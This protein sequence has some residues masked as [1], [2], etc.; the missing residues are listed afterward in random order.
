MSDDDKPQEVVA[1]GK[2]VD[3]AV[4][5]GLI[6]SGWQLE[7]IAV[8]VLDPG[9]RNV[10]GDNRLARVRLSRKTANPVE[11]ARQITAGMLE[12]MG[13]SGQ[14]Q[15]DQ[16]PDHIRVLVQGDGLEEA[17]VGGGRRGARRASA[18]GGSHRVEAEWQ[19]SDGERRPRRISRTTGAP[20]QGHGL[21]D[22][23]SG[24]ANRRKGADRGDGRCGAPGR[25]PGTQRGPRH[26]DVRP[27]RGAGEA[28]CH[29]ADRPGTAPRGAEARG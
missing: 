13:L 29:R 20:A 14:V 19:P 15:I 22:R 8:E 12:R 26:H 28:D 2:T 7:Q 10:W 6:A 17:L 21:R 1:E 3:E 24:T 4:K 27:R 23:R 5:R 18:P 25:A 16:R 11:L 9:S